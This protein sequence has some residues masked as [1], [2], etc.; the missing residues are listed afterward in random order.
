MELAY[1]Y[2]KHN[3]NIAEALTL[4]QGAVERRPSIQS[5]H[6]LALAQYVKGNYREAYNAILQAMRLGTQDASM[7]QLASE[8][9]RKMGKIEEGNKY[10]SVAVSINPRIV[11]S[12]SE[13]FSRVNVVNHKVNSS[14]E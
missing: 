12:E 10:Q 11:R 7:F 2:A 1:F 14:E 3:R 13:S 5:Y 4:A 8:I 9:S 6:T